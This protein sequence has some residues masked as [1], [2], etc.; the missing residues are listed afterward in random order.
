MLVHCAI[1]GA[2]WWICRMANIILIQV[3]A[4]FCEYTVFMYCTTSFLSTSSSVYLWNYFLQTFHYNSTTPGRMR[5]DCD[6]L[7]RWLVNRSRSCADKLGGGWERDTVQR[8]TKRYDDDGHGRDVGLRLCCLLLL[9]LCFFRHRVRLRRRRPG[10][11][12]TAA[13]SRPA[14]SRRYSMRNR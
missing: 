14:S 5:V 2:Y 11:A 9:L 4:C 10:G 13:C 1:L 7:I 12:C 3:T 8:T 6:S